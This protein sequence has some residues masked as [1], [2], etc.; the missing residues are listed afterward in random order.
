APSIVQL[1]TVEGKTYILYSPDPAK[2]EK[3]FVEITLSGCTTTALDNTFPVE[4]MAAGLVNNA[5]STVSFKNEEP[6][7]K[8]LLGGN[9][10]RFVGGSLMEME[11]GGFINA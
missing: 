5:T 10:T 1:S 4:G 3:V 6:N 9:P 2:S 8:L 7:K 11:G